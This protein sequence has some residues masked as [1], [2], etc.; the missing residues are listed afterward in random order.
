MLTYLVLG[1]FSF[2][3]S[4]ILTPLVRSLAVRSVRLISREDER[5]TR[6]LCPDSVVSVYSCR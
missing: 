5:F 3:A 6:S 2:G 4:L 1:L